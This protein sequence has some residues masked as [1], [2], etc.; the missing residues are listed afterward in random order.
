MMFVKDKAALKRQLG[1]WAES[2]VKSGAAE[3]IKAAA[4]AI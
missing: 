4:A 2:P 1:E 3:A